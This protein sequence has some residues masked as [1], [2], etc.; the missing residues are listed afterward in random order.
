MNTVET[1]DLELVLVAHN[2]AA[3]LQQ[4]AGRVHQYVTYAYA[5]TWHMTIVDHASSD[6]T[7][8]EAERAAG[9][10]RATTTRHL[11]QQL[12]RKAL[13]NEF[14]S[15][16]ATTAAFLVAAPDM[17]LDEILAPL[18]RTS[19]IVDRTGFSR[20]ELLSAAGGVG[21]LAFLAACSSKATTATPTTTASQAT[22]VATNAPT[23]PTP[24]SATTVGSTTATAARFT[25]TTASAATPGTAVLAR[26]TTRGTQDQ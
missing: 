25:A 18:L 22:T 15:S 9:W 26:R 24:S 23:S 1:L 4:I 3:D 12:S 5:G 16:E 14:T 19:A 6:E 20:R 8:A 11:P 13:H 21:A 10:L 2:Q 7:W 17:D